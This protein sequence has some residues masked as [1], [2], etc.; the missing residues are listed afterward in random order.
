MAL[1]KQLSDLENYKKKTG[2]LR[3]LAPTREKSQRQ[4]FQ[5]SLSFVRY[6]KIPNFLEH[7]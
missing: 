2:I 1:S 4:S 5:N 6:Y 3:T 7:V